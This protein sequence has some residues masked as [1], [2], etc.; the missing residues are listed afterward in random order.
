MYERPCCMRALLYF[1]EPTLD[2]RVPYLYHGAERLAI[3]EGNIFV[4]LYLYMAAVVGRCEQKMKKIA[5]LIS[6]WCYQ[7]W[8]SSQTIACIIR[9]HAGFSPQ[10]N[11]PPHPPIIIAA[12][13]IW[14][15]KQNFWLLLKFRCTY[16]IYSMYILYP[17]HPPPHKNMKINIVAETITSSILQGELWCT[18][19]QA[20][21]ISV[22]FHRHAVESYYC[23]LVLKGG[24]HIIVCEFTIYTILEHKTSEQLV[25]SEATIYTIPQPFNKRQQSW[26]LGKLEQKKIAGKV[27][28]DSSFH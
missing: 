14:S 2:S 3:F 16:F 13:V 20:W 22:I 4:W 15:D 28:V 24:N 25:V 26:S 17:T 18:S 23:E 9:H 10:T 7:R 12:D 19:T 1:W 21:Q 6:S 11:N 8:N 5:R 27:G